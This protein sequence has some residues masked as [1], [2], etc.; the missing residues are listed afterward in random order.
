[1]LTT[2]IF[3]AN[4]S[5]GIWPRA[6]LVAL[7][8]A[9]EAQARPVSK[10][11]IAIDSCGIPTPDKIRVVLTVGKHSV[12]LTAK[13]DTADGFWKGEYPGDKKQPIKTFEVDHA[14]ASLRLD[15]FRTTCD[16]NP[17]AL[18]NKEKEDIAKF[19]F[20]CSDRPVKSVKIQTDA[21]IKLDYRRM[22]DE[23]PKEVELESFDKSTSFPIP[24]LWVPGE[25]F[26]LLLNWDDT[27]SSDPGLLLFSLKGDHTGLPVFWLDSS[28]DRGVMYLDEHDRPRALKGGVPL[29]LPLDRVVDTLAKQRA[30]INGDNSKN[31]RIKNDT[32][33]RGKLKT[34]ALAVN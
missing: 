26:R 31:D 33:L 8:F 27:N 12:I 28:S 17:I 13:L 10:V 18:Q 23:C 21:P 24:S 15:G 20:K 19:T 32:R 5:Q 34:L 29:S 7:L 1:M 9:L 4:R 11:E 14:M 30:A 6:A 2:K 16:D 22:S 25:E 3:R